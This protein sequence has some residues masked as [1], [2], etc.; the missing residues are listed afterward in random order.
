MQQNK[1]ESDQID[2]INSRK[3]INDELIILKQKNIEYENNMLILKLL[4][5]SIIDREEK[6]N[7]LT[8]N[9]KFL[10]KIQ[11]LQIEITN[12]D[13]KTKYNWLFNNII[14][15][16]SCIKLQSYSI[17]HPRYNIEENI[18]NE[19]KYK[20]DDEVTS[21]E[22]KTGKYSIEELLNYIN[23]I[24]NDIFNISLDIEQKIVI[25]SSDNIELIP[26]NLITKNLGF[27]TN[28]NIIDDKIISNNTWDL[29]INDK[30][31][32][33]LN[34]LSDDIPFAILFYNEQFINQ[35]KFEEPY[36]LN[37]LDI[38]FKDSNK[39]DINFYN[40]NH[41]LNFLIEITN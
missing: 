30:V 41:T 13:N 32:L 10:Y 4:E 9:Y 38:H 36:N 1:K 17:P 40:L 11:H 12:I 7:K 37:Q 39:N 15:N 31:Y 24:S 18:N 20:I 16:V 2:I 29:R 8:S 25:T 26:T 22:I 27:I 23:S 19:F 28:L 21:I 3:Q 35:F 34:N 5:E 6:L 33:Y 14:N